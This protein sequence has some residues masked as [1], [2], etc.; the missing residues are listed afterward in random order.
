MLEELDGTPLGTR[1]PG[2]RVMEFHQRDPVQLAEVLRPD[3]EDMPMHWTR[4]QPEPEGPTDEEDQP[5]DATFS[6]QL[7]S[8]KSR[9]GQDAAPATRP[10]VQ[11]EVRQRA[12]FNRDEY[13]AFDEDAME[14]DG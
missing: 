14:E 6:R 8:A 10:T 2:N 7:R 12:D 4:T 9:Y 11:V 3:T 5:Q 1:K 13:E